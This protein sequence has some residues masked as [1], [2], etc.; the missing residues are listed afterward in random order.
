ML[1][2]RSHIHTIYPPHATQFQFTEPRSGTTHTPLPSLPSKDTRSPTP[3]HSYQV[4]HHP[5]THNIPTPVHHPRHPNTPKPHPRTTAH[6]TAL[7]A[8]FPAT[9]VKSLQSSCAV[10]RAFPLPPHAAPTA[11]PFRLARTLEW[12]VSADKWA[13]IGDALCQSDGTGGRGRSWEGDWDRR[14]LGVGDWG[15]R[16]GWAWW[17]GREWCDSSVRSAHGLDR[18]LEGM[19]DADGACWG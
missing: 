6:C 15:C 11:I 12:R 16:C 3:S 5:I 13:D 9:Q 4:A 2:L 10:Q 18:A 14:C 19:I 1:L 7:T 17:E 8:S